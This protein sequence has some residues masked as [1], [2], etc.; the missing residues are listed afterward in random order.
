MSS[1]YFLFW[2]L[3]L[4]ALSYFILINFFK[5]LIHQPLT[6]GE[7]SELSPHHIAHTWS[8]C[9]VPCFFPLSWWN[10]TFSPSDVRLGCQFLQCTLSEP[11]WARHPFSALTEA[12]AF[13]YHTTSHTVLQL[14]AFW[15]L[16]PAIMSH[17]MAFMR[18]PLSEILR[19]SLIHRRWLVNTYPIIKE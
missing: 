4:A 17:W 6:A 9:L 2:D 10:A 5:C 15:T 11:S 1:P 18:G 7:S 19:Y 14:P 16:S 3:I 12:C 8:L 13:L